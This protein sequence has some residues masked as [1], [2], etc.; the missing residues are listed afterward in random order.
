M[1]MR[2]GFCLACLMALLFA[3][4]SFAQD[5]RAIVRIKIAI[6]NGEL[7]AAYK[8]DKSVSSFRF[9]DAD[10]VREGVLLARSPGVK[11]EDN[12]VRIKFPAPQFTLSAS[13][14]LQRRDAKYALFYKVREGF[15]IF[16]PALYGHKEEW[17]NELDLTSLPDGWGRWPSSPLP[18]GYLFIGPRDQVIE[19]EGSQFAFDGGVADKTRADVIESVTRSLAFFEELFGVAPQNHPFVATRMITADEASYV[20]DVTG[21]A[22]IALRFYGD[23]WLD[24]RPETLLQVRSLVLHEV[25]HF[26]NGGIALNAVDAPSWLYEGGAEYAALIALRQLGWLDHNG[27]RTAMTGK[28]NGCRSAL[29]NHGDVALGSFDFLPGNVRYSCGPL[30]QFLTQL[31]LIRSGSGRT[32]L[33]AWSQLVETA[34]QNDRR[35]GSADFAIATGLPDLLQ[36]PMLSLLLDRDGPERWQALEAELVAAG[37]GLNSRSSGHLRSREIFM[38][39]L[40]QNCTFTENEPYG[41]H[42]RASSYVLD[43]PSGCGVLTGEPEI[44]KIAGEKPDE[45]TSETYLRIQEQ[46][47]AN[48]G[49]VLETASGSALSVRCD[50]SLSDQPTEWDITDFPQHAG[51]W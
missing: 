21:D 42:Y 39:I 28:L 51:A 26:W 20:G 8:F 9:A 6:D 23:G 16:T 30:L 1:S 12:A 48:E 38:H 32:V 18:Q 11:V 40:K 35:Y 15:L 19:L 25:F 24:A 10:V 34:V 50:D 5:D 36:R 45:L 22:M 2:I 27:L 14:D 29:Q 41:F 3:T 44:A 7:L 17:R 49:V 13:E 37:V 33:H 47:R 4:P 31:E 46:C 43:A